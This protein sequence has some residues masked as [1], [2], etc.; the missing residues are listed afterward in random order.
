MNWIEIDLDDPVERHHTD[1]ELLLRLLAHQKHEEHQNKER[2]KII[3]SALSDLQ[4]AMGQLNTDLASETSS[5]L[6]AVAHIGSPAATDAQLVPLTAAVKAASI[7]SQ[8]NAKTLNDAVAAVSTPP[9]PPP[10]VP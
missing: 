3:M 9:P 2:H 10:P 8:A 1:R 7:T 5:V 4:D 6:A